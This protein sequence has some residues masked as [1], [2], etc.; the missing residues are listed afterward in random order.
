MAQFIS[1]SG[2]GSQTWEEEVQ[3][4]LDMVPLTS[5]ALVP[6]G[7]GIT[8]CDACLPISF[9]LTDTKT[10]ILTHTQVRSQPLESISKKVIPP[11]FLPV[12]WYPRC[13]RH[14][15]WQTLLKLL[16]IQ[17]LTVLALPL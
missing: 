3:E 4:S 8:K 12:H 17:F 11:I 6:G 7:S 16:I 9:S 1:Q 15:C 2:S 13:I 10:E 14:L 5:T